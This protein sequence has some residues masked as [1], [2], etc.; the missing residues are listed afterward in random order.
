MISGD[1]YGDVVLSGSWRPEKA[2][3][4]WDY[5]SGRLIESFEWKP[6]MGEEPCLL[7]AAQFSKGNGAEFIAAGGSGANEAKIFHRHTKQVLGEVSYSLFFLCLL[8][9]T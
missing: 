5:G 3:Q 7:Y 8:S 2:L 1:I 4:T 6:A 9:L